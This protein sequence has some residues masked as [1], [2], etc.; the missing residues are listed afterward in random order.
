MHC[1]GEYPTDLK[2]LQLNQIDLFKKRYEDVNVGF[3]THEHP[4]DSQAVKL[5]VAK[6]VT[7]FEKHVAVDTSEYP[8]NGY[9]ATPKDVDLWLQSM[10]QAYEMCGVINQRHDF[11]DKEISDLRQFR[12]G[13]FAKK[14][15]NIGDV[16]DSSNVFYAWPNKDNQILSIDMS[17][18]KEN[19]GLDSQIDKI[20]EQ[21][22]IRVE[23][24]KNSINHFNTEE[25]MNI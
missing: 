12:R 25:N 1:V 4:E 9:S 16:I 23:N 20:F 5:A 18:F 24:H 2:N 6:G 10:L 21:A 15:I 14:T 7:M 11:S 22:L 19:E 3:S 13:V 17:K 8:K